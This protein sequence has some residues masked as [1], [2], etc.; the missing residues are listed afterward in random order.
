MKPARPAII[1]LILALAATSSACCAQSNATTAA[2][3]AGKTTP[4]TH[5]IVVSVDGL[6]PPSYMAPDEKGLRVPTLRALKQAGAYSP[7]V[8]SVFPTVTYPSHTSMVTGVVPAVHGVVGNRTPDPLRKNMGG[9]Y[10]YTEDIKVPT[11]W[12]VA[13][14]AGLRTALVNWPVTV[15][16]D[17]DFL[18]AEY[19]RAGTPDDVKLAKALSTP[20]L[21]DRVARRFPDFWQTFTP[22]DTLDKAGIDI[23]IHILETA[24]PD[25]MLI[26]IWMVDEYQHRHGP[27]SDEAKARIEEA[28]TQ[29]G[30][31]IDAAKKAGIW[32]R[33]MLV[34]VSDHGFLPTSQRIVPG[35]VLA[36]LGLVT[37]AAD[38]TMTDY[39]AWVRQDGGTAWVYVK[40][41]NDHA[42]RNALAGRFGELARNP[43]NGIARIFTAEEVKARGGDPGVFL[44]LEAASGFSF[45]DAYTGQ[46]VEP[47]TG[48]G[49]H[50]YDPDR[51]ELKASLVIHGPGIEPGPIDNARLIDL[52]PTMAAWLGL[53]MP[54]AQGRVLDVRTS[55]P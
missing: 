19:W 49:T 7:G 38:G 20:G 14:K 13:R 31:L 11:I 37:L 40:D 45:H 21:L 5:V 29:I 15:G 34:V 3:P 33:T 35:V 24:P 22:P 48:K 26:H 55:A 44:V 51:P 43:A 10:W 42:T 36:E 18:V 4:G 1:L 30:R 17:A 41:E 9:W 28:D 6:L 50:G 52:A 54:G 47:N 39:K 25:L 2:T 12:Q 53:S 23:G 27:W 16:A 8:L 46:L 32:D